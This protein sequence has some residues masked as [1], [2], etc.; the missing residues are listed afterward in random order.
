MYIILAPRYLQWSIKRGSHFAPFLSLCTHDVW[1][2]PMP[3]QRR[4]RPRRIRTHSLS[5]EREITQ[6][7]GI[8]YFPLDAIAHSL[9]VGRFREN[10]LAGSHSHTP[11]KINAI[12]TH[13]C[14]CVLR[15]LLSQRKRERDAV[16]P[17]FHCCAEYRCA[18]HTEILNNSEKQT[19]EKFG[20]LARFCNSSFESHFFCEFLA[21]ILA[22][23]FECD[24]FTL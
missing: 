22:L 12:C 14:N 11:R 9:S 3:Q 8:F 21:E 7:C 2:A 24:V 15:Q 23:L 5:A 6:T 18:P 19:S 1:Q 13:T 4:E 10:D 16:P 17:L 20:E